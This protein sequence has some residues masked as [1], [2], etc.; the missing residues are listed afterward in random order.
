MDYVHF[1]NSSVL[2]TSNESEAAT[3]VG[4]IITIDPLVET[5]QP[6]LD[7]NILPPL[8]PSQETATSPS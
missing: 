1:L 2:Q 6:E 8:P 3:G 7:L 5:S 4:D